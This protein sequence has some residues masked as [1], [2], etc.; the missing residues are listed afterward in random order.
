[1]TVK[2][3]VKAQRRR[4]LAKHVTRE[5]A[6]TGR[7]AFEQYQHS[8]R[9]LAPVHEKINRRALDEA[10]RRWHAEFWRRHREKSA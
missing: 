8:I 10:S 7:T 3:H 1:M 9:D 6:R 2:A 5:H 4:I